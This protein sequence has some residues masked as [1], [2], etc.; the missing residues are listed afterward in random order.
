MPGRIRTV[1][2]RKSLDTSGIAAAVRGRS[3][4][5]RAR[6][7]YCSGDSKMFDTT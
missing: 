1:N 6:K 2:V 7:S 4:A 3:S 5:G